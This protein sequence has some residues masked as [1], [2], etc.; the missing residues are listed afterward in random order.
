VSKTERYP[1]RHP[2]CTCPEGEGPAGF[3]VVLAHPQTCR[4]GRIAHQVLSGADLRVILDQ[5]GVD[6]VFSDGL[7]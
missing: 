6:R 4:G 5:Y 7:G 3:T 2:L 1:G